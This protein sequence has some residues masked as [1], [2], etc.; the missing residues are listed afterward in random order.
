MFGSF[1]VVV[2]CVWALRPAQQA[3]PALVA[4]AVDTTQEELPL[5]LQQRHMQTLYAAS[6]AYTCGYCLAAG[7]SYLSQGLA[8]RR[9]CAGL[10]C[11]CFGGV[12]LWLAGLIA[13]ARARGVFT[14]TTTTNAKR[15]LALVVASLG[16]GLLHGSTEGRP[17]RGKKQTPPPSP[18]R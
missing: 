15:P 3:R 9:W 11:C 6:D 13:N 8:A 14:T 18:R 10:Y 7:R 1:L 2:P 17:E 5:Q 12:Y 16:V 4:P